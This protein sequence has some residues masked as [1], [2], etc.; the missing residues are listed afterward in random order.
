M[1]W[2]KVEKIT[3]RKL[4]VRQVALDCGCSQGDAFM[5]WFNLWS[6]LDNEV[7]EDGFLRGY[8]PQMADQDAGLI[9]IA[10][11]L[12]R[13]G[14]LVFDAVGCSVMNWKR[15]N[16]KSAKQR[17]LTARRNAAM[18]E[19]NGSVTLPPSRHRHERDADRVS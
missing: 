18:R 17:A 3:P 7:G 10:A 8:T 4:E 16:G 9:G 14:W 12:E 1:D 6:Y 2:I 5:G 19:R 11:S 13:S 15:H